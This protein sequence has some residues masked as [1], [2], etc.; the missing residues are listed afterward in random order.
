MKPWRSCLSVLIPVSV[1]TPA[2]VGALTPPPSPKASVEV[3]LAALPAASADKI[4]VK[5]T[6][7]LGIEDLSL[8]LR[9]SA[10]KLA[11]LNEVLP[12]HRFNPGD[13]LVV[14]AKQSAQIR[15]LVSVDSSELRRTPPLAELPPVEEG[16][17]VRLGDNL[18]KIAIRY[19]V[20]LQQLLQLNPS[21][22]T[23]KLVVGSEIKI[24]QAYP[25]RPRLILGLQPTG[26]GG[27]SWP[28][29][30][31]F[32]NSDRPYGADSSETG[33]AWPTKGMFSSG[34][35]WRWGRIHKGI[36]ISNNVGTAIV[37]AK[38]GTVVFAGWDDGG[39]GYKVLL[40]HEDGSAS[41]YA[42]NSRISVRVGQ[43]VEQGALISYMG[44]TGRSTG[45][46]LHF[47]IHPPG[48]GAMNPLQFLPPRA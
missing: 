6:Q 26:S 38:A 19:G 48:R 1:A 13:W 18:K 14:P 9:L 31:T 43:S 23:A 24:A 3:L 10:S 27:I 46:H 21:L 29:L 39:Y 42:H 35:G 36:D 4:W 16:P 41:L 40:R 15:R 28:E 20:T 30:P 47:E 33:W 7:P 25:G 44:S 32:G 11:E 37:A 2:M 45:P 34:Y 12:D 17:V 22:D 8:R 5:V